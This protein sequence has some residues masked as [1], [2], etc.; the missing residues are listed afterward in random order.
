MQITWLGHAAF[1]LQGKVGADLVTV[2]TDPYS[3]E[4]TGL[5][6]PRL[7]ADIVTISHNHDDHNNREAVKG[8]PTFVEQAG[9]YEY[10]GVFIDGIQSFHDAN[11][12]SERGENIMYRFEIEDISIAHLG[13]LGHEL[14]DK[15]LER[16][17]GTDIL[18]IPVGG[19]YTIDAQKAVSVINQIEPRIIIP[20]HY[21]VP[22]LKFDLG[23]LDQF[24][25]AIAIKPRYEEKLKISK[26]ELP[27][28]DMEVVVLSF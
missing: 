26:K 25:K 19:V 9:E 4:K 24:L 21:K 28:D 16:L 2:V 18:L 1:R 10:K 23:T 13:D 15:Q 22:G 14:D 17:E 20:M 3:N 27:Q 5:K 11:K 12:G 7:E 6:L 8:E